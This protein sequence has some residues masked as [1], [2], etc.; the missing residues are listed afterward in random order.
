MKGPGNPVSLDMEGLL[1]RIREETASL[2]PRTPGCMVR[3][4]VLFAVYNGLVATRIPGIELLFCQAN[5]PNDPFTN[6]SYCLAFE[7]QLFMYDGPIGRDELENKLGFK[8]ANT[9]RE[10]EILHGKVEAPQPTPLPLG[11]LFKRLL[12][13]PWQES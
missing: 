6:G 11:N 5:G 13:R 3:W 10:N 1:R 12:M 4:E 9:E 8:L 7:K 2:N